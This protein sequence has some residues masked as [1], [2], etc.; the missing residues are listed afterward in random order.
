MTKYQLCFVRGS[1]LGG[2]WFEF[3]VKLISPIRGS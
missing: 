1:S 2:L 3:E